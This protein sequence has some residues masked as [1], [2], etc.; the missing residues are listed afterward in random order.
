MESL[1]ISECGSYQDNQTE[2]RVTGRADTAG[3]LFHALIPYEPV[4]PVLAVVFVSL[5]LFSFVVNALTLYLIE[6][7][8]DLSW[9]PRFILC[10]NLILSDLLQTTTFGP[11]VIYSLIRGQTMACNPWCYIQYIVGTASIFSSLSTITS[12]ALERYLYVCFALRYLV[13]V[14]RERLSKV[15]AL[16]WVYSISMGI[17]NIVLL[18]HSGKEE[19][20]HHVVMGLLCEPDIMEQH[21]GS[22]RAPAIFRKVLGPFTLLLCL[23]AHAFSYYRMY[24]NASNAVEPFDEV[25]H[26]ARRTVMFYLGMLFLQLLPLLIKVASDFLPESRSPG[27]TELS[28]QTQGGCKHT[29]S[30]IAAGFHVSLLILLLVPP[31]VNPLVY[32]LRSVEMRKALAD[33]LRWR[34]DNRVAAEP[35]VEMIRQRNIVHNDLAEAG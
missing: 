23:L 24:Q 33:L 25:N 28:S 6:S 15:L 30:A 35:A 16:I 5:T 1:N 17:T 31:C 8:D 4:V 18:L 12:M 32:G 11:A 14:T 20:N 26:T 19:E 27:V 10:E 22:P 7:S 13:I 21:M 29:L 2:L 3:Y 9:Q 34:G